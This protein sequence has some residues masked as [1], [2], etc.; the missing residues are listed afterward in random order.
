MTLQHEKGL[1]TDAAATA[2]SAAEQ[3]VLLALECAERSA[4]A[5]P[6]PDDTAP[7]T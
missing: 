4:A 3:P 7:S 6:E 2:N 5:E 1:T